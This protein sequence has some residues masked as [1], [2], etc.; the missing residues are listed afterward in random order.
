MTKFMTNKAFHLIASTNRRGAETFGLDL[1][2]LLE[3][4]GFP[5]EVAALAP[6]SG[7]SQLALP[8][9]GPS[10]FSPGGMYELHSRC[11]QAR[12]V[13]GHGSDTLL[14]LALAG[15][16]TRTPFVYRNI[17]DPL[18]WA[19]SPARRRRVA[20]FLHRATMVVTLW[21]ESANVLTRH[22]A[23]PTEKIAVIPN[24]CPADRFPVVTEDSRRLARERLGLPPDARVAV[25]LGALSPEKSLDTLIRSAANLPDWLVVIA[26]D[27]SAREP[28]EALSE[29]N[30][31]DRIL[32]LPRT[33]D[34]ASVIALADVAVLPSLTEGI[35]AFAIEAGLSG[36]PVV[37]TRV[38]GLPEV[39]VDG[40]TGLLVPP[41]DSE[42]LATA[43]E[44]AF[45]CR[46]EL[47]ESAR[48]HCLENFEMG[49]V[50]SAWLD[51]LVRTERRH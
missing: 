49:V 6:G 7:P 28:L 25:Y 8:V 36:L 48:R 17:G 15:I 14:A 9:L 12:V 21:Q 11:R 29:E 27:G 3:A 33:N 35:P 40:R 1:V 2:R 24:G 34:P 45:K 4:R 22:F 38:G 50:A 19:D 18:A 10:R 32:F 51:L 41:S 23:V 44:S 5:G 16:G 31:P 47:G 39:V 43:L 37:A 13:V 26:G 46:E 42:R 30:A 20:A